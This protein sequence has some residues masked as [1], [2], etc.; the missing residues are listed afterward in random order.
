MCAAEV[1]VKKKEDDIM[2]RKTMRSMISL[3][4]ALMMAVSLA[5]IPSSAAKA[6]L[7]H[8]SVSVVKGHSVTLK[9][10]KASGKITWASA[11]P[12]VATVSKKGKVTGVSLGTTT[13]SATVGKTVL[14]CKVT[15]KAGSIA[16]DG[17]KYS[18]DVGKTISVKVKAVGMHD[19]AVSSADES[20]AKAAFSSGKFDGDYIT[21]DV[22]GIAD[23]TVKIKIYSKKYAKSVYRDIEIK[24]G[25]GKASNTLAS[26]GIKVSDDFV[27]INENTTQKITVS[28]SSEILRNIKIVSTAKYYFDVETEN[29]PGK[30]CIVVTV[31]GFVEGSGNL[32]IYDPNNKKIDVN[33]PVTITNNAYDVA[34]W[35]REPKKRTNKDV[36]YVTED[37][38][39]KKFY[40][41]E[42]K[43][44]DPAHAFSVVSLAAGR[45]E[46]FTVSESCP[47]KQ[48][49]DDIILEKTEK[50]NGQKVTRYVLVPNGYDVA[51]SNS[52]FGIYFGVYEQYVVYAAMPSC[53]NRDE[54]IMTYKFTPLGKSK[55][56]TRYIIIGGKGL[57]AFADDAWN[58]YLK[59]YGS[60]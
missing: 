11:D 50:Y 3:I 31:K 27:E 28:A 57:E 2:F 59:K 20:I 51:V 58:E 40:V 56:E 39:G 34:V 12:T 22:K 44:C 37:A 1:L 13:V 14:K 46:Y 18:V 7:S 17:K 53:K 52:V 49:A 60:N 9:V 43:E 5:V 38:A 55:I 16:T 4:L 42:P 32:R 45:Y 54:R 15:V 8:S 35:N 26:S 41:L 48:K 19:L 29:D 25:K 6:V 10:G 21:F 47:I 30:G 33:I 36:V 24:V 23:G